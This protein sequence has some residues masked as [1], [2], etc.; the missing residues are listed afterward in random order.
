MTHVDGNI[1]YSKVGGSGRRAVEREG[2]MV[3][4]DVSENALKVSG[5]LF[6]EWG[7]NSESNR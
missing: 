3:T 5:N 6:W 1:G 7:P 2:A 4:T